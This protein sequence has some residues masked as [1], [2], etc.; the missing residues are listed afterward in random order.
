[1]KDKTCDGPAF[2]RVQPFTLNV[3]LK[4][5]LDTTLTSPEPLHEVFYSLLQIS[6]LIYKFGIIWECIP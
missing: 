4:P 3:E 1:M 5:T 2:I 6:V